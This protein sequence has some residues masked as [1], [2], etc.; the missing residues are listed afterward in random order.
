[1]TAPKTRGTYTV[2]ITYANLTLLSKKVTVTR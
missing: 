2:K 1:V